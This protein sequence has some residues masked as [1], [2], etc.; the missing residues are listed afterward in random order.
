MGSFRPFPWQLKP[1]ASTAPVMLVY[2]GSGPGKSAVIAE[3]MNALLKRY[4][5]STGVMMRKLRESLKNSAVLYFESNVVNGDPTVRHHKNNRRFEYSN[6]SILAYGGMKDTG[7]RE[8][9]RSIGVEGGVDFAWFEEANAFTWEDY[10]EFSTR[11]RGRAVF[12]AT[13]VDF[14]QIILTTNPDAPSH[15]IYQK[16]M[17]EKMAEVH[18][19]KPEDNPLA[20]EAY[21]NR[22]R[23]LTGVRRRRF[24]E[25]KWE[26]AEGI[27]FEEFDQHFHIIPRFEIPNDWRRIRVVDFGYVHPFCCQWW[28][29]DPDGTMYRYREIYKTRTLVSDH[30]K[31]I[32]HLSGAERIDATIC[33]HDAEGRAQLEAAGIP[34]QPAYKAVKRGIEAVQNR[35]KPVFG[36]DG[37]PIPR[38]ARMFFLEG[39]LDEVDKDLRAHGLPFETTQEFGTYVRK[40]KADGTYEEDPVKLY[41]EGMDCAR[42]ATCYVDGISESGDAREVIRQATGNDARYGEILERIRPTWS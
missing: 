29:I 30:A 14:T 37:K 11:M 5:R 13:G 39:S 21:L 20:T 18:Y 38:S 35:L 7:Q 17:L 28:A 2:G 40:R 32:K 26:A 23:N 10:E 19:A 34:T 15:W 33:D 6:G 41:D 27:I 9:M 36:R 31:R 12:K 4:P 42:Y 24:Y 1:W 22:L 8:A 16:L 25:G 3:K